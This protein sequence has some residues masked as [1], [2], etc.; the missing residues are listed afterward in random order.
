MQ[1]DVALMIAEEKLSPQEAA[2][3]WAEQ[4]EATRRSWLPS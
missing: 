2:A 3:R 4:N 1:N